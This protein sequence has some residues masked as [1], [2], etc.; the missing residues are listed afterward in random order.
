MTWQESLSRNGLFAHVSGEGDEGVSEGGG[1]HRGLSATAATD[2]DGFTSVDAQGNLV[3]TDDVGGTFGIDA[4]G[5]SQLSNSQLQAYKDV[6]QHRRP[7][8]PKLD[9]CGVVWCG[10]VRVRACV[11]VCVCGLFCSVCLWVSVPVCVYQCL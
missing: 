1:G 7:R 10:G 9:V 2:C 11:C 5:G 8:L 6:M 3:V 4:K